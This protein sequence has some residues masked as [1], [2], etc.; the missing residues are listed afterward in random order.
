MAKQAVTQLWA[1]FLFSRVLVFVVSRTDYGDMQS[2]LEGV[3]RWATK[4]TPYGEDGFG[5]PALAILFVSIPWLFGATRFELYVPFYRAQCFLAD[6]LLFHLLSRRCSRPVILAYIVSTAVLG[7]LLYHRLDIVLGLLLVTALAL[8]ARGSLRLA[9][10]T[11]GA[12]IAFKVIPVFLLPAWLLW[13]RRR[14]LRAALGALACVLLGAGS[15][16][17]LAYAF[18]G[19]EAIFFLGT[20][21]VRGV[22]IESIWASIEIPLMELGLLSGKTYFGAGSFNLSTP[23]EGVLI[24]A[25]HMGVLAAAL[26]GGVLAHRLARRGGPFILAL[27]STLGALILLSKVFSPQYLLFFLPVAAWSFDSMTPARRRL[28]M[29]FTVAICALTTWVYPYHGKELVALSA[30]ATVPLIA[31]NALFALLVLLLE[32]EAWRAGRLPEKS[33]PLPEASRARAGEDR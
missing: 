15:P 9:S 5:Y 33:I 13:A 32:L 19:R 18:W 30:V 22:Q 24:T 6:A 11:L 8:E 1:E 28:A 29:G 26:W 27:A 7:N 23:L 10:F 25:S 3:S 17:A 16:M 14:S 2:Y 21:A 4:G 31:R 20:H 12:S